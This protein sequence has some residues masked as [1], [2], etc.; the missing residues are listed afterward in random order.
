MKASELL[1][2]KTAATAKVPV[3]LDGTVLVAR[4]EAL[5]AQV[6][7]ERQAELSS[8]RTVQQAALEAAEHVKVCDEAIT[9]ATEWIELQALSRNDFNEL[10]Q[11][12]PPTPEDVEAGLDVDVE[13]FGPALLAASATKPKFTLKQAEKVFSV[14]GESEVIQIFNA[15]YAL[16]REIRKI[17]LVASGSNE[18]RVTDSNS[19]TADREASVTAIS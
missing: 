17:P 7:A 1:A 18:T 6:V 9:E 2:A 4:D 13:T 5:K 8:D 16:N 19:N 3:L 15:C 10:R 12:Y 11:A 14:W